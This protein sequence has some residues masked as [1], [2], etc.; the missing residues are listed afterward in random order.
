[1]G[2]RHTLSYPSFCPPTLVDMKDRE[3]KPIELFPP[4]VLDFSL[5]KTEEIKIRVKC[6][7][8][9]I[10]SNRTGTILLI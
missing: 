3:R 5:C 7:W 10:D 6:I 2:D 9:Q 8:R 4:H 1:V